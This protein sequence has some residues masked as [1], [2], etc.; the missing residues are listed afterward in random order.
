MSLTTC[1]ECSGTVSDRAYSCPHCG[2]PLQGKEMP[3]VPKKP[4][5]SD[6]Q[7][8]SALSCH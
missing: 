5:E 4:L 3:A 2:Y 7:T 8:G 6:V 1:P